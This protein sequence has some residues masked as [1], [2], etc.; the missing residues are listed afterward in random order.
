MLDY[1]SWCHDAPVRFLD[2]QEHGVECEVKVCI[3]CG[4]DAWL[5]GKWLTA[6]FHGNIAEGQRIGKGTT[7]IAQSVRRNYQMRSNLELND[8]EFIAMNNI[9]RAA[10]AIYDGDYNRVENCLAEALQC[11]Y[12][13]NT[14]T[15]IQTFLSTRLLRYRLALFL[16]CFLWRRLVNYERNKQGRKYKISNQSHWWSNQSVVRNTWP[17]NNCNHVK[18]FRLYLETSGTS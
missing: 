17:R 8:Y 6:M 14:W 10:L 5:N 3:E 4:G 1:L 7:C 2:C 11:M 15:T 13:V 9:K 18:P 12:K 16:F